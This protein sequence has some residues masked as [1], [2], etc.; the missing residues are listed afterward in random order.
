MAIKDNIRT[1]RIRR[2]YEQ[3][4]L[5]ELMGKNPRTVSAWESGRGTPK[6]K[7]LQ[8]LCEVLRCSLADLLAEDPEPFFQRTVT[9]YTSTLIPVYGRVAAGTPLSMSEDI[10]GEV[11][12]P[13]SLAKTGEFFGLQISGDS[14]LP[15]IHDQDI[16]IVHSQNDAESGEIVIAAV[17]GD[18]AVCK[19]LVKLP[20]GIMLMSLNQAY[21]PMIYTA[22]AIEQT[23]ITILGKV[24]EARRKF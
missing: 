3:Q 22:D 1:Y 23:P 6:A 14:M 20:E 10:I 13:D 9:S 18:D 8:R 7:D 12:I 2:G 11:E 4:Y 17:N 24:V 19:K 15:D 21:P 16:V 5:A